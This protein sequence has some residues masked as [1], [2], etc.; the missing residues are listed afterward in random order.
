M[1]RIIINYSCELISAFTSACVCYFFMS[2]CFVSFFDSVL[3][4]VSFSV[5]FLSQFASY[6]FRSS[7]GVLHRKVFLT[8]RALTAYF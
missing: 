6:L 1:V 2:L 8:A 3:A 4:F 7:S 5:S